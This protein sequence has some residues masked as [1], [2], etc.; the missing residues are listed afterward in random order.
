MSAITITHV[1]DAGT[2]PAG[3]SPT[4]SDT[5]DLGNGHNTF[6]RYTNTGSTP[7]VLTITVPGNNSYGIANPDPTFTVPITTGEFWIPVRKDYD[8]ASGN[9]TATITSTGV[10][11]GQKVQAVRVDW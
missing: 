10:A 8:D 3:Q 6:L 11:A 4:A 7:L 5:V 2:T 9:N 1:L